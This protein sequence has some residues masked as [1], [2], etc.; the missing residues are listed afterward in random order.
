MTEHTVKQVLVI[1]LVIQVTAVLLHLVDAKLG[2]VN[3]LDTEVEIGKLAIHLAV[4]FTALALNP[5]LL[6]IGALDDVVPVV[7]ATGGLGL[8]EPVGVVEGTFWHEELDLVPEGLDL[9]GHAMEGLLNVGDGLASSVN[10]L[11]GER[12]HASLGPFVAARE[13]MLCLL[14]ERSRRGD[15]EE[16]CRSSDPHCRYVW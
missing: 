8:G 7:T 10:E 14:L 4:V 15:S 1:G 2:W 5:E 6:D 3:S 13:N 16:H 9:G 12:L 11:F